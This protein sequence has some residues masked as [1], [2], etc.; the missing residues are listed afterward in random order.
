MDK[1]QLAQDMQ[2][3]VNGLRT[4]ERAA[5][6]IE[7]YVREVERLYD[8]LAGRELTKEAMLEYRQSLCDKDEKPQTVN[9]KLSGINAYLKAIGRAD[10]CIQLLKIQRR[11][12][13]D[14][15][16][17]LTESEYKRLLQAAQERKQLRLRLV[18]ETICSTG[19]RVS[20]LSFITVE[21]LRAGRAQVRLKGK[22]RVILFAKPLRRELESYARAQGIQTGCIFRT[23]SGKP[24][25][26][27]NIWRDMKRLAKRAQVSEKKVFPHNLRHLFAR[28][29]YALDKNLA[30][31]ADILG[32]SS[33][34]TTRI[35]VSVS[36]R[37]H[38]KTLSKMQ[39]VI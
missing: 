32:H 39:L 26:R 17:E 4:S 3:F 10:C 31:L 14:E 7:K 11:A 30:H 34:E 25:D 38:E 35:Y 13:I 1:N 24:L 29:Y 5:A 12:F 37:E 6:T 16:R 18:L 33:V 20:E 28:M 15:E 21:A 22:I 9:A 27:S 36:E 23:K 8:F 19:I 2:G